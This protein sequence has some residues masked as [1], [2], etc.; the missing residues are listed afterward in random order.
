MFRWSVLN[1]L[2]RL[3]NLIYRKWIGHEEINSYAS[4]SCEYVDGTRSDVLYVPQSP[5][6]RLPPVVVEFQYAAVNNPYLH[7]LIRYCAHIISKFNAEP[8]AVTI[9]IN[10]IPANVS[11]QLRDIEEHPFI[12]QFASDNWAQRH[13]FMSKE[14]IFGSLAGPLPLPPLVALVYVMTEQRA[15]LISLEHR[16]DPTV[17]RLYQVA[18]Y[19]VSHQVR[20]E[21]A[22]VSA[23]V[24]VCQNNRGQ[25][26]RILEVANKDE[27]LQRVIAYANDGVVYNES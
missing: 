15:S 9:C 13:Y 11:T 5:S 19:A 23:L 3:D 21:E 16:D 8:I 26:R 1:L 27:G 22:T 14:T 6:E 2:K 20:E 17:K 7:R 10:T 18:R 12:K 25:Y 4:A 24:N